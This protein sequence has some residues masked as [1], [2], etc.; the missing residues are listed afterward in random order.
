MNACATLVPD[1]ERIDP[2][3]KWQ[4]LCSLV[5]GPDRRRQKAGH[6]LQT[7]LDSAAS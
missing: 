3:V 5:F 2:R 6:A 7:V 4:T 1:P